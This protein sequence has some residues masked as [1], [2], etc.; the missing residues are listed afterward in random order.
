MSTEST[1]SPV[2]STAMGDS[3]LSWKA[4]MGAG[5]LISVLGLLAVLAPL[6]TGVGLSLLLG[7]FLVIGGLGH[8]AHAFTAPGW[9]GS[10]WQIVLALLYTFAGIA[11]LVNPVLGLTSLTFLLIVYFAIEGLVEIVMGLQL[12]SESQWGWYV[13]SGVLS[14]VLAGLLWAGFPSTAAWAVG[15]LVGI[16]LLS[17]GLTL[18]V[19]AYFGR[20]TSTSRVEE[21]FGEP[22]SG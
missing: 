16:G 22:G 6:V 2:A 21:T 1:D 4:L 8:I 15:L 18:I 19:A 14:L 3:Q 20:R 13:A 7:A 11:L 5:V 17:T 12:R 9:T 10:L